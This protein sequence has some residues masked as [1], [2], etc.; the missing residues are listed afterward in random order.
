[1][2]IENIFIKGLNEVITFY[3]GKNKN[4]NFD[5]IDKGDSDDLWFHVNDTSSCHVVA[6]IPKDLSK[7]DI[8][9]IVKMGA[10]L[11]KQN[12]SKIKNQDGIEIIYTQIKNIEKTNIPGCV[13]INDN[14]K[15]IK[16]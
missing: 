5:V 11:C 6:I 2:K 9:Y 4:E 16:I 15:C 13:K 3:I 10:L 12:T 14:K 1:M 7:K 8:K